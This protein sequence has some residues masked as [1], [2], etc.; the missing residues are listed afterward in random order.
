MLNHSI[1]QGRLVKD[2]ELKQAAGTTIASFTVACERDYKGKD[3][4]RETD[5]VN[6]TAFGKKAEFICQ[7][8]A[9][10]QMMIVSG[11]MQMRN[12]KDKDG[13]SRQS[14]ELSVEDANF[15]GSSGTKSEEKKSNYAF[16]YDGKGLEDVTVDDADLPF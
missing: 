3:G 14:W 11:R 6:C 2:P 13:N 9:K 16:P 8:F 4:K 12:W 10:G 15:D 5:F 7:Y 1:Y